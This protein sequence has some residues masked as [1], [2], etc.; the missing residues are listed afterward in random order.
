MKSLFATANCMYLWRLSPQSLLT[1]I[2]LPLSLSASAPSAN[3]QAA[4]IPGF[5]LHLVV[6]D[7]EPVIVTTLDGL[8]DHCVPSAPAALLK[9]GVLALGLV[10]LPPVKGALG[11]TP[12]S[13]FNGVIGIKKAFPTLAEQLRDTL[14]SGLRVCTWSTLP[15]GS[16]MGTSS[17]LAGAMLF[18]MAQ[19]I[20]KPYADDASLM[21][22]VLVL[23]QLLTTGG[24]WQDQVG[25]VMAGIKITSSEASLPLR[26]MPA[27]VEAAPATIDALS[28]R[29]V[30]VYT[31]RTRL[32]RNL[33][34]TVIRRW[35]ERLPEIMVTTAALK[36][37]AFAVADAVRAGD[38]AAVGAC[39]TKYWAHKK[40]MAEGCEPAFCAKILAA[41]EPLL[42]GASMAGAGGG[43][44][45]F[46]I[47]KEPNMIPALRELLSKSGI[48]EASDL[49]YH[50]GIIDTEGL[51]VTVK[52]A[53]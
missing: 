31:G 14:G 7:R 4:R 16:G 48:P 24:G 53:S 8:K 47:T 12:S 35:Y 34:Q 26:V 2:I 13:S 45:M 19:A 10:A 38:V 17:I 27:T 21:H 22:G 11:G 15:Q 40:A 1:P 39:V 6:G 29:I 43:G 44:F 25:G 51:K 5:E 36:T 32:A 46:L 49:T 3:V 18:A 37:N 33:L 30:L 41:C 42:H 9:A 50:T 28:K 52:A 23:E 20:G